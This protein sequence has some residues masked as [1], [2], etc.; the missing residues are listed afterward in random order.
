[1]E[2]ASCLG[3]DISGHGMSRG[4]H[5]GDVDFTFFPICSFECDKSSTGRYFKTA[6]M[7]RSSVSFRRALFTPILS[8]I[9]DFVCVHTVARFH[10]T[11]CDAMDCNPPG[12]SVHGIFQARIQEWVAVS[13]SRGPSQL[14]G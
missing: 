1:M 3:H 4:L 13:S 11:L 10:P 5:P 6:Q 7:V 2:A 12:S 8:T 9:R 14:R